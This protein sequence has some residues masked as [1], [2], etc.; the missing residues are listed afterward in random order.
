MIAFVDD[1]IDENSAFNLAKVLLENGY[2]VIARVH[3]AFKEN[4]KKLY[5]IS[6]L[7]FIFDGSSSP[8]ESFKNSFTVITN[9]SS[10]AHTYPLTTLR[11]AI[12][13]MPNSILD[14]EIYG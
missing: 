1:A 5:S 8:I 14:K 9:H 7:N 12:L 13:F 10:L 6:N 3:P 2:K 4:M 11:K